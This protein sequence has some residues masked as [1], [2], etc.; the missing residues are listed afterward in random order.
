M[1]GA[2]TIF[3][4]LTGGLGNQMFQIAAAIGLAERL[5]CGWAC[6]EDMENHHGQG[7]PPD[8]YRSNLF[9][10]LRFVRPGAHGLIREYRWRYQWIRIPKLEADWMMTGHWQ[11]PK[12]WEHCAAKVHAAFDLGWWRDSYGLDQLRRDSGKPLCAVHYRGGDYLLQRNKHH[13]CGN[14]YY[15]RATEA[16]AD[17]YTLVLFADDIESARQMNIRHDYHFSAGDDAE[18]F[19]AMAHCDA[20]IISNSTFA[21]W[22]MTL[23]RPKREVHVPDRWFGPEGPKDFESIYPGSWKR[24]GVEQGAALR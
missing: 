2:R 18:D 11:S 6:P 17:E 8:H 14:A 9:R 23:G 5:G 1:K 12:Y 21:W 20:G 19:A 10:N 4:R 15:R 16:L 13:V 24:H 22:A 7:N 3:P